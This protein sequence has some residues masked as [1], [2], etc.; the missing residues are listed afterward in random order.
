[1]GVVFEGVGK[2]FDTLRFAENMVEGRFIHMP[3]SG[4]AGEVVI[5][6]V[7][8]D[9]INSAVGDDI[10]VHFFLNPPR[11]RKL[12]ISGIYETNL[13]EYYDS[14]IIIGDLRLVQRLNNSAD[15]VAGGLKIYLKDPLKADE[16]LAFIGERMDYDLY[17]EKTS[18][19]YRQIF[20]WLG[21]INRQVL[22][23]LGIILTVVGVNMVSVIL[24]L[25]M[26][27]TQMI[28]ML[29][30]LGARD[31][32]IRSVFIYSGIGLIIRGLLF[33]NLFG[34]GL[35]FL[36]D[37]FKL[38][39]LNPHDYYMSYVP[40]D[41]NWD[42]VL[43]LNVLVFGVIT[44]VLLLPAAITSRINPIDAIRFD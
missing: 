27:R 42:V 11:F 18:E 28:G 9:K 36:Q 43:I 25:V 15:S 13:S 17:I 34:L 5:S 39:K 8:A 41:W 30:A 38:I 12:K 23:L 16:A 37:K 33:G 26:E 10:I 21:L 35:C 24:I 22:I 3:D 32:Q 1:M 6:R 31:K 44:L 40:I 20:E 14:R 29:K 2:S 7:I 4:Y 19:T